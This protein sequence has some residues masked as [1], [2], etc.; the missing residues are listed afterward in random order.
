[1]TLEELQLDFNVLIIPLDKNM[2][3]MDGLN[4]KE[5]VNSKP[6]SFKKI[7]SYSIK[8]LADITKEKKSLKISLKIPSS[9]LLKNIPSDANS[10]ILDVYIVL[11]T[12]EERNVYESVYVLTHKAYAEFL[13]LYATD[14]T[15]TVYDASIG[16][17]KNDNVRKIA[18]EEY[19]AL[20][21]EVIN[22]IAHFKV[23]EIDTEEILCQKK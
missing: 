14:P 15:C 2:T 17:I 22:S 20:N 21:K 9:N 10:K 18:G 23:L 3:L 12:T 16:Y 7:F 4:Y 5:D 8:D 19:I 13:R 1:M 11:G 6:R